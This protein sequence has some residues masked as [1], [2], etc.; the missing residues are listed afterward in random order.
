[1]FNTS[2]S[3]AQ[4]VSGLVT[5]SF[6]SLIGWLGL[7][8]G[9]LLW[10]V[11]YITEVTSGRLLSPADPSSLVK[12]GFLAFPVAFLFLGAGLIALGAKLRR[13]SRRLA[14]AGLLVA[15]IP[16]ATT[17]ISVVLRAGIL[18]AGAAGLV[19]LVATVGVI[20]VFTSTTLISIA[21]LR[22]KALPGWTAIVL[23][24]TGILTFP[25][26][27]VT[28]PLSAIT[29]DYITGDLPFALAGAMFLMVGFVAMKT[30]RESAE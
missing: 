1:M 17:L 28:I 22:T 12:F 19:G 8:V 21:M 11:M 15:V 16:I 4:A 25:L 29:P 6:S 27:L 24:L 30:W 26:I 13:R 2:N 20:S 9:G 3:E 7:M 14:W 5:R 10:I 23:L 18:G